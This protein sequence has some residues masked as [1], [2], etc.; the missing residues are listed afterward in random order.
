MAENNGKIKD[1]FVFVKFIGL[2]GLIGFDV[3]FGPGS[4]LQKS[5]YILVSALFLLFAVIAEWNHRLI[6]VF[7]EGILALVAVFLFPVTGNYLLLIGFLDFLSSR[8]LSAPSYLLGYI[9]MFL[10]FRTQRNLILEFVI[11][12]F[13][14]ILYV[15]EKVVIASYKEVVQEG[16]ETEGKLKVVMEKEKRSHSAALRKSRLKSE[17]ELLEERNRIAQ[18]MHDKLGHSI[19]GSLYQLEAAK[20]LVEKKPKEC[21]NILQEVID[22]LRISMD[23][24][25]IILRREKPDKKRMAVLSLQ[26]LCEECQDRYHIDA[27]LSLSPETERIGEK[28][29]EIIL[30]NTY[31]AVTNALKY[32]GCHKIKIT[33][34]VLNQ[35]VRCSICD[36]GKGAENLTEG[37]GIAGMKKRVRDV[38]GF[39]DIETEVGFHINMI[40]PI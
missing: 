34:T 27:E 38:H 23:E 5:F 11:T 30:D 16:E 3:I 14:I 10:Y 33:I 13:F 9:S 31:E 8:K 36:D 6:I 18:A 12:T 40:L 1:Y 37:M 20:L 28:I 15:Q 7:V 24:I 19:N 39:L 32:S 21:Q 26:S 17:N 4:L 22:Q 25:R 29:W 35:V 2:L